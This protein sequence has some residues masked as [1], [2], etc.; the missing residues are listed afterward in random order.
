MLPAGLRYQDVIVVTSDV[1]VALNKV[2]TYELDMR[3]KRIK[4]AADLS[5]KHTYLPVRSLEAS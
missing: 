4:R 2:D 1:G 3:N 5:L